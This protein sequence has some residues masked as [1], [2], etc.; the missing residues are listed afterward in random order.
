M[1]GVATCDNFIYSKYYYVSEY[2]EKI[3]PVYKPVGD[4]GH[5]THNYMDHASKIQ[6]RMGRESIVP[7]SNV[8]YVSVNQ[9]GKA[10]YIH[11]GDTEALFMLSLAM[12]VPYEYYDKMI[13]LGDN[14]K[15]I[16]DERLTDY[17][18]QVEAME[19]WTAEHPGETYDIVGASLTDDNGPDK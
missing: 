16:A 14:L 18:K 17:N 8:R 4:Y 1:E 5:T 7:A 6:E 19:E 13:Y 11:D 12:G 3:N 15:E 10:F 2:Y 9:L